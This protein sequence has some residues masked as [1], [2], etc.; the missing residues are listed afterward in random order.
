ME[1]LCLNYDGTGIGTRF[2]MLE[3]VALTPMPFTRNLGVILDASLSME[4][5]SPD[6]PSIILGW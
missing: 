1:V 5:R 4:K 2:L 6:Q 3:G